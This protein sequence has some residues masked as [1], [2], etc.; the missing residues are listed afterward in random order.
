MDS[1]ISD[2]MQETRSTWAD[3]TA[4]IAALS[5]Q[6]PGGAPRDPADRI[7][8]ATSIA[9][10]CALATPDREMIEYPFAPTVW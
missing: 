8:I 3:V 4:P 10:G 1:W 2:A 5:N 6:L 9:L 7:I